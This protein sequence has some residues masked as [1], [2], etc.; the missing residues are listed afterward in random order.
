MNNTQELVFKDIHELQSYQGKALPPGEWIAV[1]QDMIDA[2]AD[3]T[4]DH[5]WIHTDTARAEKESPFKKTVAHGF[6]SM[7][8]LSKMLMDLVKVTSVELGIN[9]GL[10]QVRFPHP[11]PV[12]SYVRLQSTIS[13]IETYKDNGYKITWDCSIE[14]KGIDKPACVAEFI[15][16]MFEK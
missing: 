2:F 7:S 5:Q 9:Y 1:T 4:Q 8:L 15:S 11:V 16:L 12:N 10:N 3:A 6:L 14:I 13:N